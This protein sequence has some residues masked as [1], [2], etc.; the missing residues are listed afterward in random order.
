MIVCGASEMM[1]RTVS[2]FILVILYIQFGFAAENTVDSNWV[3]RQFTVPDDLP[4]E[5]VRDVIMARDGAVWIAT[6]GGGVVRMDGTNRKVIDESDGL[7]SDDVRVLEEDNAGRIW[8]G[9]ANGISCIDGWEIHNFSSTTNP[10]I[11][12]DSIFAIESMENGE[13][14]FGSGL[15][16]L[17]AWEP[18]PNSNSVT[19]GIWKLIHR[20]TS[21]EQYSIREIV[22]NKPD[23][24]IVAVDYFGLVIFD[25]KLNYK[26]LPIDDRNSAYVCK[27]FFIDNQNHIFMVGS[28]VILEFVDQRIKQKYPIPAQTF[29]MNFAFGHLFVGTQQGLYILEGNE[30]TYC[31]LTTD[32]RNLHIESISYLRDGS[33]WV[34]TRGGAYRLIK[35][36]WVSPEFP[37]DSY[38]LYGESLIQNEN[39]QLLMLDGVMYLW[40]YKNGNWNRL[41][42]VPL[43]FSMGTCNRLHLF[44]NKLVVFRGVDIIEFNL[45]TLSVSKEEYS[46]PPVPQIGGK[47]K[48]F[49]PNENEIWFCSEAG[50]LKYENDRYTQVFNLTPREKQD[51]YSILETSPGEYWI[52]GRGWIEH[53]VNGKGESVKLPDSFLDESGQIL[54]SIQT[55]EGELWFSQLGRG[56][57]RYK[58]NSWYHDTLDNGLLS[59]YIWSLFQSSD[60]TIWAGDRIDGIMSYKDGRWIRYDYEDG[61]PLGPVMSIVEDE[62]HSIW[63]GIEK[64]GIFQ[65]LP[66]TNPPVVQIVSAPDRLV[67]DAQGVFSFQGYDAWNVTRREELVYSWRIV[68]SHDNRVVQDWNR[69]SYKT[70]AQVSP[71]KPGDYRF[72][73]R[74][75]DEHRNT[76]LVPAA[77]SFQVIPY[78][79]M[80]Y[81]F[82]I[83]VI[84]TFMFAVFSLVSWR[85]HQ[86]YKMQQEI[87]AASASEQQKISILLH[88]TIKQDL[89]GISYKSQLL[90]EQLEESQFIKIDDMRKLI[91]I[92]EKTSQNISKIS[93][94]L[95][96][97]HFGEMDFHSAM[98]DLAAT[99][100]SF[101]PVQ[102]GYEYDPD[103]AIENDEAKMHLYYIA[104][105]AFYNAVRHAQA[106]S[107]FMSV[108]R[109]NHSILLS[110]QDDGIGIAPEEH[111]EGQGLHI[112]KYRAE[113]IRADLRITNPAKGGTIVECRYPIA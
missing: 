8:V 73:V 12:D 91:E 61:I 76:C 108:K 96:P 18:L 100:K 70:S 65:F 77:A 98:S 10:E 35:P 44:S 68:N 81:Q 47:R 6:W 37:P 28:P 14:W 72:E 75:Q 22:Q 17:F 46:V 99:M 85:K 103:A 109:V 87:V 102:C 71:L 26:K 107:V 112:M 23:E 30:W 89:T 40:T 38:A 64:V 45:S 24:I 20:F 32:K 11:P 13:I 2:F 49:L 57:L 84:L 95:F 97:V 80:T 25:S 16:Q 92:L 59:N 5:V 29:C 31:P 94:G 62:Q 36:A 79:W 74:V 86:V 1:R 42:H 41:S 4:N 51:V 52:G 93:K 34:G 55:Q 15:A 104:H 39:N 43:T 105:E 101:Y 78:F 69:Y 50:I 27:G 88:D 19:E 90:L 9:T 113:L 82:W 110:I 3:I 67:P 111:R 66:D 48:Y 33:L 54:D 60:S 63:I 21:N 7:V 53:W 106:N 58:D 56:I 83:P